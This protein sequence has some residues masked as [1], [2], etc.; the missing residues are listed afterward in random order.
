MKVIG[1]GNVLPVFVSFGNFRYIY[2]Y[3]IGI[4]KEEECD[5][6]KSNKE[7]V[8][9]LLDCIRKGMKDKMRRCEGWSC[10]ESVFSKF[11]LCKVNV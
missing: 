4:I 5:I 2:L 8:M 6:I 7:I 10:Q 1:F 11:F 9:H 3:L